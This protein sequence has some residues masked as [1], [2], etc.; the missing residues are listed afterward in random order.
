MNITNSPQQKSPAF[1][2][3]I[4]CPPYSPLSS[5]TTF[6]PPGHDR[7]SPEGSSCG[8]AEQGR[9][10]SD[11]QEE[12]ASEREDDKGSLEVEDTACNMTNEDDKEALYAKVCYFFKRTKT[13]N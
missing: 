1:P 11:Q 9:E 10:E 4:P 7:T 3:P 12:E 2:S 13:S 8:E 6:Q 5:F